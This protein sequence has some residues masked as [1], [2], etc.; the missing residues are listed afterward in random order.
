ML[1][2]VNHSNRTKL[3]TFTRYLHFP[4][5]DIPSL[6]LHFLQ[7]NP[8]VNS[9]QKTTFTPLSLELLFIVLTAE[10]NTLNHLI[11]L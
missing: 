4:H 8:S 9:F 2:T 6:F 5:P 11:E 1:F 10:R 3:C 7:A